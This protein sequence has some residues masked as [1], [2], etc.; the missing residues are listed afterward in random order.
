M[1]MRNGA[2]SAWITLYQLDG[3]WSTIAFETGTAAAP[4]IYF[5]DSGTDTGIYSPGADQVGIST[6][7][8][9]RIT[10]DGSGN[11]NIDSNTLYVDAANSR[12][13][14]GTNSPGELLQ[15][16]GNVSLRTS[17]FGSS[18]YIEFGDAGTPYSKVGRNAS[19]GNLF[20]GTLAGDSST[21]L[22]STGTG[23]ITFNTNGAN[24]R[25]RFD[26]SGSLLVGTSSSANNTRLQQKLAIVHAGTGSY[27]GAQFTG[28]SGTTVLAA[29][30]L[31]LCRSRG[32]SDGTMTKVESGDRVGLI[33]FR[34]SD[35]SAF[36]D[37]A[38]IDCYAD[39]TTGAGDTP[40]RLVFSVTADG[41][42]SP[43]EAM[44]IKN[45]RII[46]IANTP[47]Y[48]DNAAA[49]TGGLVDGDVYRKSDGTLMIVYT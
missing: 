24:E 36:Q 39:G 3:E 16:N 31:E 18:G 43:T 27:T 2:N 33:Q 7:G 21:T 30:L 41:A 17:A 34:G 42:A 20:V 13:G 10:V 5:K 4:S 35:G 29:P 23:A 32:T 8:T 14:I 15:V 38:L 19:S 28:Y 40:G 48:A 25:A 49:K 26:T 22:Q 47:V 1:K 44:R 46:N 11:V 12:V 45:S 6:G 9:A 37:M